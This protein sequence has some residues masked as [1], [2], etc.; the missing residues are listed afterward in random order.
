MFHSHEDFREWYPPNEVHFGSRPMR[1]DSTAAPA[2]LQVET[3]PGTRREGRWRASL[4]SL[5]L[6]AFLASSVPVPSSDP[7]SP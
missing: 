6:L 2:Y 5:L 4:V 3:R 1:Q 7:R